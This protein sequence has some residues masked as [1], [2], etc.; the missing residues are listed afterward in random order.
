MSQLL[1]R[2]AK[3][4]AQ[5]LSGSCLHDGLMVHVE[6]RDFPASELPTGFDVLRIY[7]PLVRA[8]RRRRGLPPWKNTSDYFPAKPLSATAAHSEAFPLQTSAFTGI[9]RWCFANHASQPLELSP[10]VRTTR[11]VDLRLLAHLGTP[12]HFPVGAKGAVEA[13]VPTGLDDPEIRL[14]ALLPW[15][16]DTSEE[17]TVQDVLAAELEDAE[18]ERGLADA[19]IEDISAYLPPEPPAGFELAFEREF[20]QLEPGESAGSEI[21]IRPGE[22]N[23]QQRGIAF[24]IEAVDANDPQNRA[25]SDVLLVELDPE[26]DGTLFL[27]GDGAPW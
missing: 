3:D 7:S 2:R 21:E 4:M 15:A 18:D 25:V 8:I 10:H 14:S 16:T 20:L 22:P 11:F 17:R 13:T 24:A 1:W 19:A 26:T 12:A 9:H 23:D 5:I 27:Y 6:G